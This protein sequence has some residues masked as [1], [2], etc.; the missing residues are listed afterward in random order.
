MAQRRLALLDSITIVEAPLVS[1]DLA[2]AL[3]AGIPL[4]LSAKVDAEHMA[5]AASNGLAYLLTWDT[6]HIANPRLRRNRDAIF[7][8]WGYNPPVFCTPGEFMGER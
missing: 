5:V 4:P 7:A 6:R 3:R 8:T 1:R 2:R